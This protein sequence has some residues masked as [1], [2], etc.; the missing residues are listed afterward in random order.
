MTALYLIKELKP[1]IDFLNILAEDII[2][3]EVEKKET[4]VD[5]NLTKTNNSKSE[6]TVNLKER[7]ENHPVVW[8]LSILFVGFLAGLGTYKGILEIA[9]L[10]VISAQ[11]L[12]RLKSVDNSQS[13][14]QNP[15]G[16]NL[17]KQIGVLTTAHNQRLSG[18][19]KQLLEAEKDSSEYTNPDSTKKAY[20]ESAKRI[21]VLI[22]NEHQ[23][24]N[25]NIK[26]L[27]TL[28]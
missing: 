14:P 17:S 28:Q 25:E 18:L 24:F 20:S 19:Q 21:E 12:N 15:I 6:F 26:V 7:I 3:Y 27:K 8:L 1:K 23:S 4:P 10:K 16:P 11:E 2:S 9:H 13:T 5:I 22:S